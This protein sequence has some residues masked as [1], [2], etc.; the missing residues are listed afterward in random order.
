MKNKNILISG[1]G[2]AG[3]TL[4]YWLKKN[5]FAPTLVEKHPTLRTGGY[6]IDIRGVAVEVI[7]RM[8]LYSS[9]FESRTDIQ[10]LSFVDSSGKHVTQMSGDLGGHRTEED[11]EINRGDLCQILLNEVG[12]VECLFG[13]SIT[14]I[15]ESPDG[16]HMEFERSNSRLFDLVV[17]ADGLHSNIRNLVFGDESQF[18]HDLGVYVS[19]YT[20]PN[21]LKL[22]RWEIEYHEPKRFINVYSTRGD[23]DAKANFAFPSGSSSFDPRNTK[24]Q[25]KILEEA[26]ANVGWEA[27][28]LIAA[29]KES[30]DF[31]FD[32]AAQIQM[33]HW[34]K[35]RVALVG[36]AG[37]AVSPLSGQGTS[38]ALIGAY[39]LACE[40]AEAQG[41]YVTAYSSY[42]KLL[43]SFVTK[44]QEIAQMS[45]HIMSESTFS[46]AWLF[47][48]LMRVMPESWIQFFKRLTLKRVTKAAN[49]LTLKEY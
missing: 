40:L 29:M 23:K 19:V 43:Q 3:L 37:Y 47:Y 33:P 25:Q 8:G 32:I 38:C 13:D 15:S 48:Y 1:A 34:S 28:N 6:K 42:E 16:V 18:L 10:G 31:Y 39:V 27:S 45:K 4:A 20:I 44:N 26:F 17:G 14:H 12:D 41:D 35:G 22:D 2:I 11:L 5:G 9:I 36:D 49:A 24:Q 21:F 30:P 7:K 46:I